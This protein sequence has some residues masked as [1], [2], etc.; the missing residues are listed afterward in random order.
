MNRKPPQDRPLRV[1]HILTDSNIGGAGRQLLYLAGASDRSKFEFIFILPEGARTGPEFER[2]GAGVRYVRGLRKSFS[3][4]AGRELLLLLKELRPDIVHTHASFTGRIAALRARVPVRIMT[5]HS[6]DPPPRI[7]SRLPGR[8]LCSLHW[9]RTLTAAVATD[10]ES[11][12]S[13]VSCGM[14][15]KYISV[16]YNGAPEPRK[17][18]AGESAA[19]RAELG[20]PENAVV[21]GTFARL[22]PEKDIVTLLR[23]AALCMRTASNLYFIICGEG[24]LGAELR[25]LSSRYG[26]DGRVIFC[27]FAADPAPYMA[28]CSLLVSC[29]RAVE[30]SSLSVIEGMSMGLV[31]VVTDVGGS[32]V[33]AEGCGVCVPPC[34]PPALYEAILGLL[35]DP[36]RRSALSEAAR[37]RYLREFTAE[38]MASKTCALYSS[39]FRG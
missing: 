16:I 7:L 21:C 8:L 13:L 32:P 9:R 22:E 12:L 37:Q 25:A 15:E 10:A 29:S 39:L 11:A 5:R 17:V 31:P 3:P 19:L 18:G 6:S 27:G 36:V 4:A 1:V 28:I 34:D 38:A 24:S 26:L 23:A 30:T 2:L 33:L 14:P 35:R 20:I